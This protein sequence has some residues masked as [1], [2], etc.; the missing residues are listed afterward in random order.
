VVPA[1]ARPTEGDVVSAPSQDGQ[2]VLEHRLDQDTVVVRVGGEVDVSTCSDLRSGLLAL[3]PGDGQPVGLVLNLADVQFIDSTGIG[4]LVGIW[5]R[6]RADDGHM[7]LATPSRQVQRILDTAGLAK[8]L[9]VYE[10]ESQ[11][12]QIT[13]LHL[14]AATGETE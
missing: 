10:L 9:P 7:V 13:Q 8:I 5:R 2:L 14:D 1:G 3:V 12:V 4:V 11:A 6:I